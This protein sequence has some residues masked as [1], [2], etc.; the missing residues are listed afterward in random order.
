MTTSPTATP[1]LPPA[2]NGI[3]NPVCPAP[4]GPGFGGC[5]SFHAVTAIATNDLLWDWDIESGSV[6]C[7]QGVRRLF[8]N[9]SDLPPHVEAWEALLHPDERI[10]VVSQLRATLASERCDWESLYRMRTSDNHYVTVWSRAVI[11]RDAHRRAVRMVGGLTDITGQS[12]REE[13]LR[14]QAELLDEANDAIILRSLDGQVRHWSG[15][16]ERTYGWTALDAVGKNIL[17][18]IYVDRAEF[19]EARA[20]TVAAGEWRGEMSHVTK[21]K[22][23]V[24]VRSRWRLLRNPDG[25]PTGIISVSS[26]ITDRKLLE[27][28]LLRA[29][30]LENI[31]MLASGIAH[32]LNNL[33]TPITIATGVIRQ[34]DTE[35]ATHELLRSVQQSA[36]R[37]AD[38]IRQILSFARGIDEQPARTDAR[39]LVK[40]IQRLATNTFPK[41]LSIGSR[42]A[43]DIWSIEANTVQLHQVLLNL[44]VNARDAMPG[45]G[46]L[47]ITAENRVVD[48]A[49]ARMQPHARPGRYVMLSVS[50]TGC[51]I[52]EEIRPRIFE[53]LFTT[54]MVGAGTGLG[55]ATVKSITRHHLGWVEFSTEVNRGTEFRVYLPAT[56]APA[57][58]AAEPAPRPLPRGDGQHVLV[59]DDDSSIRSITGYALEAQGYRATL[60]GDG[61]ESLIALAREASAFDLMLTDLSM[62]VMDGFSLIQ[63]V[64]RLAPDL[65]VIAL[66]GRADELGSDRLKA[67]NISRVL[68][69]PYTCDQLLSA[70]AAE[71]PGN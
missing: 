36:Q 45:G 71:L 31:G 46:E 9:V 2:D 69:K 8:A 28:Q 30:R 50:D 47:M 5:G 44:C 68:A 56:A 63:A 39:F 57:E 48:E 25:V 53:P 16:A 40:E 58:P 70:I 3:P 10:S 7:E 32:D 18:L 29:Q 12:R 67:L 27:A 62:P 14:E 11:V 22:R 42:V 61:A 20:A 51:G 52:P 26:E 4:C 6:R 35:P 34:L 15:G 66:S 24:T 55:L 19:A 49:Y 41:N 1:T 13:R 65:P 38:L 43:Q 60:A 64:R 33:L 37:G 59:V 21:D 17:N 23:R 54:K